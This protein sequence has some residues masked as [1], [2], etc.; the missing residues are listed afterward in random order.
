MK[1]LWNSPAA[2]FNPLVEFADMQMMRKR[3]LGIKE[4]AEAMAARL[5]RAF[6][7][8]WQASRVQTTQKVQN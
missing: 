7:F 4:R 6:T 2:L 1:C 3:L 8:R 5:S